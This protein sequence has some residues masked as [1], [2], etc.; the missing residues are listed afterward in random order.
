MLCCF[1]C[2]PNAVLIDVNSYANTRIRDEGG[3]FNST[4]DNWVSDS[5]QKLM[6][7]GC[8]ALFMPLNT[9]YRKM[10]VL[11]LYD[12]GTVMCTFKINFCFGFLAFF[13]S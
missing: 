4:K 10:S 9:L 11:P 13:Q 12:P 1:D 8:Q 2:I 7:V 6:Q 5:Y 3:F